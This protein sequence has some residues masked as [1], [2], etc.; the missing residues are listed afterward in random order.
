MGNAALTIEE[1]LERTAGR[2]IYVCMHARTARRRYATCEVCWDCRSV[3]S[4]V[5]ADDYWPSVTR[6]QLESCQMIALNGAS[7]AHDWRVNPLS[8]RDLTPQ[9]LSP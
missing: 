7:I 2:T 3:R 8:P 4:I 1:V 9:A 5:A 6:I